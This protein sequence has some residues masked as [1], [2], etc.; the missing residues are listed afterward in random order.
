LAARNPPCAENISLNSC[1]DF[2]RRV[3][4]MTGHWIEAHQKQPQE[5]ASQSA[6]GKEN[7]SAIIIGRDSS[8]RAA[9]HESF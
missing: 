2:M 3:G 4:Q 9:A 6:N 1:A 8:N 7:A 5:N